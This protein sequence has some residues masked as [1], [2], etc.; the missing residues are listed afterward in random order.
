M[1]RRTERRN[2]TRATVEEP[3]SPPSPE[4]VHDRLW[5]QDLRSSIRCSAVLLALLLLIDGGAGTLT[6]PRA[7][8]WMA[9]ALLLFL[10]LHPT[11][12]AAGE[13]WLTS[14]GLLRARRVRTDQLVSVR[15]LDGVAQRLVLRDA[16]GASIEIDPRVLV[17]NPPPGRGRPRLRPARLPHLRGDGTAPRVGADRPGDCDDRVQGLGAE[18]GAV[19][20]QHRWEMP[21]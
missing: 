21:D 3:A 20:N 6:P 14:R 18:L 10:V 17:A 9:L 4:V 8:L 5:A 12:V 7:A 11:R 19:G 1:E 13:G 16:S 15:C 2:D